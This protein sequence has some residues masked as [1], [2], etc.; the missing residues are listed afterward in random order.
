MNDKK[1][2]SATEAAEEYDIELPDNIETEIP[3]WLS[4][5]IHRGLDRTFKHS[6]WNDINRKTSDDLQSLIANGLDNGMST[7]ELA[8]AIEAVAPEYSTW[9]AMRVARTETTS[10]MSYAQTE[11]MKEASAE[12]GS[13]I[14]K[15]WVSVLGNTTRET[16][17][18]ADG[19][20]VGVDEKFTVGG[21]E[22]EYPGDPVLPA[23]ERVNCQCGL[24]SSLIMEDE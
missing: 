12:I 17:A 2:S 20:I 11:A 3:K 19:Q 7:R 10:A 22:C 6:Y 23:D 21:Y 1:P 4:D 14:G 13:P 15:E 8:K 18:E 9:R 5:A 24:V 16:H